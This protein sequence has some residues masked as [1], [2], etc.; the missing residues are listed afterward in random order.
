MKPFY[1]HL[2]R[3]NFLN[4]KQGSKRHPAGMT[5]YFEQSKDDH[6]SV[7]V[8]M[9]VCSRKDN[10]CKA[11]GRA[12]A[13]AS[14]EVITINKRVVPSFLNDKLGT[15]GISAAPGMHDYVLRNFV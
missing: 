4:H 11:T 5:L 9:S 7:D 8:R 2:N 14:G 12:V 13:R 6:H 10:F 1:I 15:L 3:A